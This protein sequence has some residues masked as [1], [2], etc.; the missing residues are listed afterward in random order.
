VVLDEE[1]FHQYGL[2]ALTHQAGAVTVVVPRSGIQ[3]SGRLEER[4]SESITVDGQ[5]VAATRWSLSMPDGAHDV[6]MDARGRLLRV[7]IPAKGIV[8][9]RDE[10]PR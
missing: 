6:W 1:V 3:H 4:G 9:V 5:Q 2:L 7:A 10:L 8:A